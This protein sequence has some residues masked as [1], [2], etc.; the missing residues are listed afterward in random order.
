MSCLTTETREALVIILHTSRG[1]I[2]IAEYDYDDCSEGARARAHE[3][4]RDYVAKT[5]E[6]A[7]CTIERRVI[8][9]YR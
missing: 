2:E 6:Y 4:V 1:D 3:E 8:P 5:G 9:I 7:Y